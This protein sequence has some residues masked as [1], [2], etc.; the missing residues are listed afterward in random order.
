[1]FD[2]GLFF[3]ETMRDGYEDWEFFLRAAL[4]GFWGTSAGSVGFNYRIRSSS[5]VVESRKRHKQIVEQIY[6]R[7]HLV[8]K[9]LTACEHQYMPRFRFIDEVG[10]CYDFSDPMLGPALE[11]SFDPGYVPPI[12]IFGSGA[13]FELLKRSGMLRGILF[14]VQHQVR[15]HS[16]RVD[17][18]HRETGFGFEQKLGLGD[19]PALFAFQSAWLADG[20][21]S[22]DN[23]RSIISSAPGLAISCP[24]HRELPIGSNAVDFQHLLRHAS[25]PASG[26]AE[27]VREPLENRQASHTSFAQAHQ[28]DYGKTIYPL[29]RD[30][31]IDICFV[32]SWLRLGDIDQCVLKFAAALKRSVD[33][34]RL[35]L[36]V[37]DLLV[38]DFDRA[39]A[40][41]IR[42][43]RLRCAL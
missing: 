37:T 26:E 3:D 33:S 16:L 11:R 7:N 32:V 19:N 43:N 42:R 12:T 15:T 10:H 36:L 38:I 17:L 29:T 21:I 41:D 8:P 14:F 24:D 25:T 9:S 5:M 27:S 22:A 13:A 39:G 34:A 40:I 31:Q 30:D 2:A 1:M 18:E 35:H 6:Q 23:I 28:L 20:R 4:R